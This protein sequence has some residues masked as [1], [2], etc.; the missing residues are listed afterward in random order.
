MFFSTFFVILKTPFYIARTFFHITRSTAFLFTRR[1]V[2]CYNSFHKY[3]YIRRRSSI[4]NLMNQ[5]NIVHEILNHIGDI[6]IANLL[7]VF[8]SIPLVTIGPSLT[9]LYHCTLRSVKGNSYGMVKTFFRAFKENFVQSLIVWLGIAAAGFILVTNIR[10][11]G[12]GTGQMGNILM[13]LSEGLM[14]LLVIL[15]LYVFPVIAAFSSSTASQ[16]K[17]A[18]IFAFMRFPYTIVLAV[19]S[20]FPMYMTYQDY[21]LM[22][23]WACCWFFFGFGLTANRN[24]LLL[25]RLFKPY[26]EKE[27]GTES[28]KGE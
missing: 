3:G 15:A 8:C 16:V 7:F 9:A 1:W 13:I 24:S 17:N 20:V 21:K 6:V 27:S 26:L 11:L 14:V 2:Q 19:V 10:F 25:Y 18:V 28:E 23:L 12:S 22:P 4:M 5:D